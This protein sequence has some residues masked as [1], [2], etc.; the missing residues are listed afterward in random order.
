MLVGVLLAAVVGM[1]VIPW[2]PG[3]QPSLMPDAAVPAPA[4]VVVPDAGRAREEPAAAAAPARRE[5]PPP[6]KARAAT[7]PAAAAAPAPSA[8]ALREE[9]NKLM[10]AGR[11][12]AAVKHY[13]EALA[14]GPDARLHYNLC[15]AYYQLG[16][17]G[18]ALRSCDQ[19]ARTGASPELVEKT[20]KLSVKVE[21]EIR[22]LGQDPAQ[23]RRAGG[24]D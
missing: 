6:K 20:G 11:Y 17:F 22:R 16:E 1:L 15:T 10:Y 14:Q 2:G 9:G 5:E 12:A 4:I 13:R 21:D 24:N 18:L 8:D 23:L 19:V 3:K 7:A